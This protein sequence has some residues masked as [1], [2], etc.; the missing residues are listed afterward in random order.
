[1]NAFPR[2]AP[3]MSA[4]ALS[5]NGVPAPRTGDDPDRD[6]DAMGTT[7]PGGAPAGAGGA[8]AGGPA[9]PPPVRPTIV[10]A[11]SGQHDLAERLLGVPLPAPAPGAYLALRHGRPGTRA[12]VPGHRVP[13]DAGAGPLTRPPRR[14]AV[15]APAELLEYAHLVIAPDAPPAPAASAVLADAV[16]CAD[17]LVYLLDAGETLAPAHGAELAALAGAAGRL[18]LVD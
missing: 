13:R 3:F 8:G 2:E 4:I 16:R 12:F 5:G 15:S 17:G 6:G 18:W 7:L 14:I 11:G 1:M 10:L 9:A